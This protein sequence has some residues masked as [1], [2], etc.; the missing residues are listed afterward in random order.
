M[1][2]LLTEASQAARARKLA[3][4]A[5]KASATILGLLPLGG[6]ALGAVLGANFASY[7]FR[8]LGTI[9]ALAGLVALC[10]GMLWMF[11]LVAQAEKA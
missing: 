10:G 6:I 2:R 8:G 5:P 9:S 4:T 7:F 1:R 11:R 3:L